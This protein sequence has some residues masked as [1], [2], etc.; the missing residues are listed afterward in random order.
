MIEARGID[1]KKEKVERSDKAKVDKGVANATVAKT[2]KQKQM[3]R[4]ENL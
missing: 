4:N 2:P 3:G 1:S